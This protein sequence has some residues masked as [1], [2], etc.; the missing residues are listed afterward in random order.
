[1]PAVL[2][3]KDDTFKLEF[4]EGVFAVTVGQSA[5]LYDGDK[6]LGGGVITARGSV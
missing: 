3:V 4:D 2:S 5:V 1:V 6:L